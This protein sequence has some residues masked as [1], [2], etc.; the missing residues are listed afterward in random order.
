MG[1]GIHRMFVEQRKRFYPMP[2]Y[3][4]NDPDRVIVSIPGK[5]IDPSY[6]ALLMEQ[7]DLPLARVI[8]LDQVQKRRRL[9]RADASKLRR[10]K[11]VEGRF[12]NLYV[13]AHVAASTDE[14]AQYIR[15]RAFDDQ[16]YKAM[17][18]EYLRKYG[19]ANRDDLARLL[20]DKLSEILT[21]EQK[22]NKIRN[23][24][25]ALVDEGV[26]RNIGSRRVPKYVLVASLS[27]ESNPQ[28]HSGLDQDS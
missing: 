2:D 21:G 24:R 19:S 22:H 6:T 25:H 18:V 12:P 4:L 26:I 27:S 28:G 10:E 8:L 15:N 23:L 16:H 3:L 20:L 1:Y 13:A 17:I 5:I 14:K 9:D 7:H 11:L